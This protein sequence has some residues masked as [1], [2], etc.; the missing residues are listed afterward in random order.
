MWRGRGGQSASH[1]HPMNE[2][3]TSKLPLGPWQTC[4][5]QLQ[6][7]N[8]THTIHIVPHTEDTSNSYIFMLLPQPPQPKSYQPLTGVTVRMARTA[9]WS[10]KLNSR[11]GTRCG[12]G[13]SHC[14]VFTCNTANVIYIHLGPSQPTTEKPQATLLLPWWRSS[15]HCH[16]VEMAGYQVSVSLKKWVFL[17]F[18]KVSTPH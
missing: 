6:L 5:S 3:R 1:Y 4:N 15:L 11:C 16:P 7:H 18:C 14:L 17:M 12:H 13:W 8:R 10:E 2:Q 9:S